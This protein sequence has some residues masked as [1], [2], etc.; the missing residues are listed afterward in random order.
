M[1]IQKQ[2]VQELVALAI[3]G[4]SHKVVL[5]V[6]S[7]RWDLPVVDGLVGPLMGVGGEG[8]VGSEL[9]QELA[10][11]CSVEG[12]SVRRER[13]T[14]GKAQM[15]WMSASQL[16]KQLDQ[17]AEGSFGELPDMVQSTPSTLRALDSLD[18]LSAALVQAGSIGQVIDSCVAACSDLFPSTVML[19]RGGQSGWVG[20]RGALLGVTQR[21]ESARQ[22]GM[23]DVFAPCGEAY[24]DLLGRP[25]LVVLLP[26]TDEIVIAFSWVDDGVQAR[27]LAALL[28]Q[29]FCRV[30]LRQYRTAN[31]ITP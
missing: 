10:M 31:E 27:P 26:L 14:Q 1:S 5:A 8:T 22:K 12:L 7:D 25:P 13:F 2:L 29:R 3:C 17:H 30:A 9:A 24:E 15:R 21:L 23:M 6:G 28:V 11:L 20:P 16:A 19:Q 4:G 18:R